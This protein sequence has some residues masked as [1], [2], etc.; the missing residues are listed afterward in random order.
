[1]RK[2]NKAKYQNNNRSN[3]QIIKKV[4][5]VKIVKINQNELIL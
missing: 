4:K 2:Y 1:V 5:I 3:L